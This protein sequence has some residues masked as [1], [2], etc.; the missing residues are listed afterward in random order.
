MTAPGA[1]TFNA[2]SFFFQWCCYK[3][4]LCIAPET[5]GSPGGRRPQRRN[6]LW[7][8]DVRIN[9]TIHSALHLSRRVHF[10]SNYKPRQLKAECFLRTERPQGGVRDI[11]GL[12]PPPFRYAALAVIA[13]YSRAA[14]RR[15]HARR[16]CC[17]AWL[18][19]SQSSKGCSVFLSLSVKAGHASFV[20]QCD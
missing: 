9:Y 11:G 3:P 13:T 2:L 1:T 15:V 8:C 6:E 18:F 20:V 14:S 5:R 16:V 4:C 10:H 17:C 7:A 12:S 19:A